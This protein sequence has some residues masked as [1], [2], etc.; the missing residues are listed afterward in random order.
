[1]RRGFFARSLVVR[2]HSPAA[3]VDVLPLVNLFL[4]LVPFLLLCATFAPLAA[5]QV[6]S[7]APAVGHTASLVLRI[8]A[9]SFAIESGDGKQGSTWVTRPA[10]PRDGKRTGYEQLADTCLRIKARLPKATTLT[11][12]P[13]DDVPYE[14]VIMALDTV[15]HTHTFADVVLGS[16]ADTP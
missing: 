15:R 11:V 8:R 13:S 6:D 5:A 12:I 2:V 14:D 10:D 9:N 4:T 1:M 7:L 3:R 16:G